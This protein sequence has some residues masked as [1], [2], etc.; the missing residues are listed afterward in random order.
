MKK[1]FGNAWQIF[2]DQQRLLSNLAV[3][4]NVVFRRSYLI[5]R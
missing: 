1:L 5:F 4:T 2:R 3:E